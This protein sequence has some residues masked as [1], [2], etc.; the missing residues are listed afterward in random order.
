MTQQV[1]WRTTAEVTS[2][3][4]V[5][6]QGPAESRG[7]FAEVHR[8]GPSGLRLTQVGQPQVAHPA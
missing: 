3:A 4:E 8:R 1:G 7:N 2:S 6:A 5:E